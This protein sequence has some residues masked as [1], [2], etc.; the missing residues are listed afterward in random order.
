MAP[1]SAPPEPGAGETPG[2]AD[3]P[4]YNWRRLYALVLGALVAAIALLTLL[5]R[6]YR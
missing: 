6:V 4:A 1:S 5:S 3:V 2:D